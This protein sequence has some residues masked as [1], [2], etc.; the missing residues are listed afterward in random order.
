MAKQ[1]MDIADGKDSASKGVFTSAL[2]DE[3]QRN[4]TDEQ[5]QRKMNEGG[6]NY[7]R[8]REKLNFEVT[9]GGRIQTIDRSKSIPQRY[10][11]RLR[12]F[13][14]ADPDY[15]VDP[16]TGEKI[17]TNRRTTVKIVFQ[18]SRERMHQLAYGNQTVNLERGSDNSYITRHQ[19]IEHWAQ[20]IYRFACKKWGEDNILGFYCHLDETNPHIHCTIFPVAEIKGKMGVSF[21][22]VFWGLRNKATVLSRLHDELAEVNVKW[23]LERGAPVALT[24]AVHKST[25]EYRSEQA[26]LEAE[27]RKQRAAVK[28]LETM[29]R[30]LANERDVLTKQLAL[31]RKDSTES[32]SRK[33]TEISKLVAQIENL[34]GQLGDKQH[35]LDLANANLQDIYKKFVLVQKTTQ[36]IEDANQQ[37]IHVCSPVRNFAANIALRAFIGTVQDVWDNTRTTVSEDQYMDESFAGAILCDFENIISCATLF[38]AGFMNEATNFAESNGGGGSKNDLPWRDKDDEDQIWMAKCLRA[39]YH[40]MRPK[41]GY[42]ARKKP[43]GYRR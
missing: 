19:D 11:E 4:W 31:I 40:M 22:K 30:N 24:G 28:G 34:N 1:V 43:S 2:S 39:A 10:Q 7:D 36:K 17:A 38:F 33:Q 16:R 3:H 41:G 20:D 15:K 12:E 23:G 8:T 6:C 13:G 14:I 9:K 5:W 27:L 37:A 42:K 35:K 29:I 18:G 21:N 32:L 26:S 25:K